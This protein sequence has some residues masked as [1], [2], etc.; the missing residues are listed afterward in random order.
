MPSATEFLGDEKQ[1][2]TDFLKDVDE[3]RDIATP[4]GLALLKKDFAPSYTRELSEVLPDAPL[5][6]EGKLTFQPNPYDEKGKFIPS[7]AEKIV[8]PLSSPLNLALMVG[9]GG[10]GMLAKAA[11]ALFAGQGVKGAH[12]ASKV[13]RD[14]N[15][16]QDEK[17]DATLSLFT[18]ALQIGG[19]AHA[20][21]KEPLNPFSLG[22]PTLPPIEPAA[23]KGG[24]PITETTGEPNAPQTQPQ[25]VSVQQQRQGTD[26][27]GTPSE[28]IVGN[29]VPSE[30]PIESPPKV[31]QDVTPAIKVNDKVFTGD[32]HV[33]AYAN[34]KTS[35]QPDTSG[36]QE[37]FVK[38]GKF[39]SREEAAKETG[40]P[41]ATEPVKLNSSDLETPPVVD[42]PVNNP[43]GPGIVGT[44]GATPSEFE[45]SKGNPT[46]M[47]YA[48]I[49]NERQKRGLEPLT[50]P[51]SVSDQVVM[52]KA[53]A[54]LDHD[55]SIGERLV[56]ELN[57]K[58]RPISDLENH[59]LML[60]KI[61]LK[62]Q[63]EKSARDAI[64]AHDDGRIEDM[65]EANLRTAQWSDKL[66][67]M[68]QASRITGSE[69]GRA[70]R[71]LRVMA[72]EDFS[73]ASME[74][75][76]RAAKGG[77]PLTDNERATMIKQ[78]D[79]LE[80][81]N[82]AHLERIE[83]QSNKISQQEADISLKQIQLEEAQKKIPNMS[84]KVL[85]A[86]KRI[87]DHLDK[88]GEAARQRIKDRLKRTSAGVDP[89]VIV[90]LADIV[91]QELGH[92]AL[93][94]T[95]W[96]ARMV[97][98]FG[99]YIRP[100]LKQSFDAGQEIFNR[101]T[102][103]NPL[104]IARAMREKSPQEQIDAN[105]AKIEDKIKSG[106]KDEINYYVQ[107][108]TRLLY[109]S[110]VKGRDALIDAVHARMQKVIPDITKRETMDAISG[111]GEFKP[112]S[113][114][115]IT[116]ELRGLKGEMQQLSKLED[117]AA[118]KSPLKS[119]LERRTPTE[120]ER[121]LIKKVEQSKF[122]FQVPMTDPSTQLKSALD[123]YKTGLR[124]RIT[125]LEDRLNRGD[126]DK[127]PRRQLNLDNDALRLRASYERA[128]QLFQSNVQKIKLEQRKSPE[129]I[130]DAIAKWKRAFILTYPTSLA[131]LASA[132]FEGIAIS[133]IEEAIGEGISKIPGLKSISDSAPR[134]GGGFN[135]KA[136]TEAISDTLTNLVRNFKT[137]LK[138]GGTDFTAIYEKASVIPTEFKEFIGKLHFALK[139][140][141]LQNEFSRSLRKRLD[142][143]ARNGV[144]VTEP[145]IQV[146]LMEEARQTAYKDAEASIFSENN[147]VVDMYR[148]AL[149]R[150]SQ[151]E[152]GKTAT[153]GSQ[154]AV[155]FVMEYELPIV[156]IPT[157]IVKRTFEY[158]FG[159]PEGLARIAFKKWAGELDNLKPEDA[160]LIIRNLKRGSLG[161]TLVLAGFL[162]PTAIGGYY[163]PGEKRKPG[164]VPV[165]GLRIA[166]INIPRFLVHNP[167]LEQLQ[168][169]STIRRVMDSRL[170]KGE[171]SVGA[172]PSAVAAAY[173]GLTREVPFERA[174]ED[175]VNSLNPRELHK[176]LGEQAKS[177]VPGAVQWVAQHYDVDS[178]GNY[179]RRSPKTAVQVFKTAIPGL[180][181]QV[182]KSKN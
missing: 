88:R 101:I 52:D 47:K 37:G 86:T 76:M 166:G 167:L 163:Q 21:V 98:E 145:L 67:K 111:Y 126:F 83:S 116:T 50:K 180:R 33:S 2:A 94:F 31:S 73:L 109:Q 61:D 139:T 10:E 119:G 64:Q 115:K 53:M 138:T 149:S 23:I 40:L 44:G 19:G 147:M 68:E 91:A 152:A 1:S 51:D 48:L 11:G 100:Y 28:T 162:N 106:K 30:T 168:I 99:E 154:K 134:H 141:L 43:K 13:L 93:D 169:G 164:D 62:D 179:V 42:Q 90:D 82:A 46:A 7:D 128:K 151:P 133:P 171:S 5:I 112:L 14:P 170:K 89:T 25:Q 8:R 107:R 174:M 129:K 142:F 16:S 110:G 161:A 3:S 96:S 165:G 158:S 26:E 125:D 22:K 38:D 77:A 178:N 79:A 148:R 155:K 146:K 160:D 12:D 54:S 144:D 102:A 65:Q 156:K 130:L 70:L 58:P 34:A 122:E 29:R 172:L 4:A 121:Q 136:E 135:F 176:F 72:N 15:A 117:M 177:M 81:A 132:A 157:N 66:T 118:G 63:Y 182:P 17:H 27:G 35:G 131:K 92:A 127:K 80:K 85:D 84:P 173:M 87:V 114:D 55:P 123:T 56:A 9:T 71:S 137:G 59:I 95:E 74:T 78:H 49:D 45:R 36:A 69:R 181:E 175:T 20:L 6:P 32:D 153:S 97:S 104:D 57:D 18:D 75:Q 159:I 150:V 143:A 41:T 124:N 105:Q 60:E 24:T 140:P 103:E 39:I 113:K 108:M 120:A